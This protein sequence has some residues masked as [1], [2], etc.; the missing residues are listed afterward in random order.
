MTPAQ[1]ADAIAEYRAGLQTGIELLRQLQGI[2]D[3]QQQGSQQR[4][5]TQLA[6]EAD[7]RT[8]LTNA[9]VA[10][11]PGLVGV[12]ARLMALPTAAL[13]ARQ[14]YGEVLALRKVAA[15]LV[16]AILRSDETSMRALADAELA[17]RAA[18]ATLERGEA[19]LAAYRRVLVPP[20]GSASLVD[21]RG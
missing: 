7:T 10:L 15:D 19:T 1:V 3:R 5:F 20:A 17:H 16:A 13:H 2:A 11:E 9:L 4:D 8:R 21:V 12:R 6:C 14:D 18:R